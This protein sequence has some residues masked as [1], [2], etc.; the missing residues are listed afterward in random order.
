MHGLPNE[1]VWLP[2][3]AITPVPAWRSA[4]RRANPFGLARRKISR[5][6]LQI[7]VMS[8]QAFCGPF[9]HPIDSRFVE[10]EGRPMSNIRKHNMEMGVQAGRALPQGGGGL[11]WFLGAASTG[12]DSHKWPVWSHG[13][14]SGAYPGLRGR[15]LLEFSTRGL[16]PSVRAGGTPGEGVTVPLKVGFCQ[17]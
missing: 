15:V 1:F 4:V 12:T 14:G 16:Q 7:K 17:H 3:A 2:R 11:L 10:N 5:N 9:L 6:P 13:A 8:L